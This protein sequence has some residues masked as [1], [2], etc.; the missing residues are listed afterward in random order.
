MGAKRYLSHSRC[1]G[2]RRHATEP[3]EVAMPLNHTAAR[4][5]A[6]LLY[7]EPLVKVGRLASPWCCLSRSIQR[8]HAWW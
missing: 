3:Q 4:K 7:D 5:L 6:L 2:S 1:S 8:A